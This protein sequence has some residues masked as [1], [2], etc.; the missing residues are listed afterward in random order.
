MS[1]VHSTGRMV[2]LDRSKGILLMNSSFSK[3]LIFF[4]SFIFFLYTTLIILLGKII[5]LDKVLA[6]VFKEIKKYLFF[7]VIKVLNFPLFS[8]FTIAPTVRDW[9]VAWEILT[10]TKNG[11]ME[12]FFVCYDVSLAKHECLVVHSH[13]CPVGWRLLPFLVIIRCGISPTIT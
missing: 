11:N 13:E 8:R 10:Q 2:P 3:I 4:P 5:I 7:K 6:I 1:K 9:G 12:L